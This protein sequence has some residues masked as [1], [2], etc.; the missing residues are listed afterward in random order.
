MKTKQKFLTD[1]LVG[2]ELQMLFVEKFWSHLNYYNKANDIPDLV[3]K[4]VYLFNM[5]LAKPLPVQSQ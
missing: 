4:S 2:L 3:F 1:S 5:Y